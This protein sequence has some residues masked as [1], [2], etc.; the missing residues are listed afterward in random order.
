MGFVDER[1][2]LYN[3]FTRVY[4]IFLDPYA[5]LPA[6][7]HAYGFGYGATPDELKFIRFRNYNDSKRSY[8]T[9][10]VFNLKTRSWSQQELI[11][12]AQIDAFVGTFLKGYLYWMGPLKIMAL[13]VDKMEFSEMHLPDSAINQRNHLGTCHGCL[14]MITNTVDALKFDMWVKNEQGV[15]NLWSKTYSYTLALEPEWS[16]SKDIEITEDGK[17]IMHLVKKDRAGQVIFDT[18]KQSYKLLK[19]SSRLLRGIIYKESLISPMNLC[20]V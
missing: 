3:P 19:R 12:G 11:Q 1:M 4:E 13:N 16:F 17:V 5:P 20:R 15:D 2:I 18:S 14:W 6:G 8:H 9:C 10:D 7:S